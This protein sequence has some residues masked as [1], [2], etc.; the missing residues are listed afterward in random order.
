MAKAAKEKSS[1]LRTFFISFVSVFGAFLGLVVA[2]M[3]IVLVLCLSGDDNLGSSF[4]VRPDAEGNRKELGKETP[5]ILEISVKGVIGSGELTGEKIETILLK[6][7]EE[8]LKKDRVK[9]I[10]LVIDSPGGGVNDSNIIYRELLEYKQRYKTPIY[11]YVDGLA[12]SGGYYIA[13][14]SDKIYASEVSVIGSIGVLSWPPYFNVVDLMNKI[15]VSAL[16]VIAGKDKDQLNPT[17]PWK[18][19]EEKNSQM[20]VDTF[21]DQF[22]ALVAKH[23]P[24]LSVEK[25]K[26]DLGAHVYPAQIALQE[27][28]IDFTDA[29]RRGV[30][31]EL[32]VAAGIGPEEKYQV[33]E[34][35]TKGWLKKMFEEDSA[36]WSGKIKHELVLPEEFTMRA[37]NPFCY[38]W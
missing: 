19:G 35:E 24:K 28:Y 30:L 7:R 37:R 15:G 25:L 6:S 3:A 23:R 34:I 12:A 14:A 2:I 1:I 27:G 29:T 32:A 26:E 5:V 36:L 16:T 33:V 31:K 13:C 10:L 4:K 8:G 18:S 20:L 17:R 9:A 22:V 11:A 21:Y 38:L